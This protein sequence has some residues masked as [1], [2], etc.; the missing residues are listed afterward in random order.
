MAIT[1]QTRHQLH[2]CMH[3]ENGHGA[4]SLNASKPVERLLNGH[5]N[6]A[7]A[8]LIRAC[9]G[10]WPQQNIC[11]S[12]LSHSAPVQSSAQ[13]TGINAASLHRFP[14]ASVMLADAFQLHGNCQGSP[15]SKMGIHR[16]TARLVIWPKGLFMNSWPSSSIG[17]MV[18]DHAYAAQLHWSKCSES[19]QPHVDFSIVRRRQP[20]VIHSPTMVSDQ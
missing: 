11:R 7:A 16:T 20:D 3:D 5:L 14:G 2:Q 19:Q 17:R 1:H 15:P 9:Q 13:A 18:H 4:A 12:M 6:L 8:A 10:V